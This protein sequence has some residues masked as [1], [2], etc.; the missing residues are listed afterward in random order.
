MKKIKAFLIFVLACLFYFFFQFA[1]HNP[2]IS[3]VNVFNQ[4][5]YD[6]VGSFGVLL[7]FFVSLI[8]IFW[9]LFKKK[10]KH[11]QSVVI[12]WLS[13][14]ITFLTD[15]TSLLRFMN[16]WSE[17][18]WGQILA[19]LTVGIAVISILTG[20]I[21]LKNEKLSIDKT[22]LRNALVVSVISAL[23]LFFY[24]VDLNKSL[25]GGISAIIVG[26]LALIINIWMWMKTLFPR[27]KIKFKQKIRKIF[28]VVIFGLVLGLIL[29]LAE[30]HGEGIASTWKIRI[31]VISVFLGASAIATLTGY[32]LLSEFLGF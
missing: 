11:F 32:F 10:K 31:T 23:I 30:A 27:I 13:I 22:N 18:M 29:F 9:A 20:M 8:S 5:P 1:K 21:L 17:S 26:L 15:I 28:W 2:L 16:I 14:V 25:L 6:A 24:P 3:P 4:D 7:A 12:V 19:I